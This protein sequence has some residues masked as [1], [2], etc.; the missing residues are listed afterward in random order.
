MEKYFNL[1]KALP[2]KQR[3]KTF[4]TDYME[5]GVLVE[6]SVIKNYG[7]DRV[8]DF[9]RDLVPTDSQLNKT[10]H[11]SWKKVRDAS[12]EQ[13][14]AEQLLHYFSTYGLESMGFYHESTVYIPNESLNLQAKGGITF[15]TLR[16]ITPEEIHESVQRMISSGIAL[17][18]SDLADLV[19]I[20]KHRKL[21]I[22][23][24]TSKNR[25][26]SVR[27][28]D[29]LGVTPDNP[30]E[31]LR[32]QV[33]LAT[34]A[35]LLIKSK[36]VFDSIR[37][38]SLAKQNNVFEQYEKLHG[39]EGLASVFYRFKPL[40]MAFKNKSSASTVNRIRKL[41]VKHH[42]PMPEDYLASVTKYLRNGT[43]DK[44]KLEDSLSKANIF[45]K[46]RLAQVLSFYGDTSAS[47]VMYSVRNGKAFVTAINPI[48]GG[49]DEALLVVMES[50]SKD[51][52][53]L[54]GK[55]VYMNVGLVAPTSGKAFLGDVPFGSFFSTKE[56]LVLGVLWHDVGS[57]RI[58]LDLSMVNLSGKT[59]WDGMYRNKNLLFSGDV[60]SAPE[61]AAEAFLV[62]DGIEDGVHLLNLNYFNGFDASVAVPFTLF[63]AK[64][65]EFDGI[66]RGTALVSQ[67]N[68]LFWANS[69][70]DSQRKQK[71]VGV[72][73]VRD[74]I[75]TFHVFDS[76]VGNSMTA[77]NNDKSQN[78]IAYYDKHLDSLL[79]MRS[80]LKWAG[81][82]LVDD[83]AN[84]DID[85]SIASLTK[86]TLIQ[87]VT[88]E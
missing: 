1:F 49:T 74:G 23:P 65:N 88:G 13:L 86:D 72:L 67:D 81:A 6:D 48:T 41:A 78:M 37:S 70:I 87:L 32:L 3:T 35:S 36:S 83:P 52:S 18:D 28:Y 16:G 26:M 43:F 73:R 53:H 80:L 19:E 11:K 38:V 69:E 76:K 79:D 84:A 66:N 12:I 56:S 44:N 31:Y 9:V 39:L 8:S 58:D 85:L 61:G 24:A 25:E 64:E 30:I 27:L 29:M 2:V 15:Y 10:F 46:I 45:R 22:D 82:E 55:R 7:R 47:G 75:K 60:T 59:G 54:R 77:H 17:S 21:P 63:V 33:Y 40:F 34:K 14:V 5:F 62:R 71:S 4:S 20:I 51:L 57:V 50:L 68:M 42:R